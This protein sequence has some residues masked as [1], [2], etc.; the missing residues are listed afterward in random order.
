MYNVPRRGEEGGKGRGW[1]TR[2]KR[3]GEEGIFR[4]CKNSNDLKKGVAGTKEEITGMRE[5][6]AKMKEE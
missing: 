3:K 6:V 2:G 1:R 4:K 5:G